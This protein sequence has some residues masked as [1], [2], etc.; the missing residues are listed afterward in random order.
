MLL[1]GAFFQTE[2]MGTLNTDIFLD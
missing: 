1:G 2:T